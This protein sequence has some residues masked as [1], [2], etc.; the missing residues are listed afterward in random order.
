[1]LLFLDIMWD[2]DAQPKHTVHRFSEQTSIL[3]LSLSNC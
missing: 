1:M 3:L 2:S